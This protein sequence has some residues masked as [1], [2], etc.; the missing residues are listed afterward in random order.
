MRKFDRCRLMLGIITAL[1]AVIAF[2]YV[3]VI[4]K[5]DNLL[6]AVFIA[7]SVGMFYSSHR[8]MDGYLKKNPKESWRKLPRF[9]KDEPVLNV[10]CFNYYKWII[11]FI[12]LIFVLSE[13]M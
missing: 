11:M 10:Y 2:V 7:L 9:Q 8:W 6:V 13:Y 5:D 1:V 4:L 3:S 12:V